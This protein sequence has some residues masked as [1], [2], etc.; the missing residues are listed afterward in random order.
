VRAH[1][2]TAWYSRVQWR[3]GAI[4]SGEARALQGEDPGA[5]QVKAARSR[6]FEDLDHALYLALQRDGRA[7]YRDLARELGTSEQ[8]VRRRLASLS[9]RGMLTFRTDFTRGEGGWPAQLMLWLAVP[10]TAL[11]QAG[12]EISA[13]PQTRICLSVVGPANMFVMLQLHHLGELSAVCERL[14]ASSPAAVITDQRVVL[15]PVKSWGRLLDRAGHAVA[16][17][18]VDPWAPVA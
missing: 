9:R 7:H 3:L 10:D 12:A 6:A 2:G 14:R 13:W 18:P 8:L 5:G 17:V 15:R 1:V 16:V 4:S 11:E